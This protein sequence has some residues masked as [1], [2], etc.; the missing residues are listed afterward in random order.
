MTFGEGCH[1]MT[2]LSAIHDC[3]NQLPTLVVVEKDSGMQSRMRT[4]HALV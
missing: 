1:G 3:Y 4:A 2:L